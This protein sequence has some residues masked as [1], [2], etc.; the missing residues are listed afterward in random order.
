MTSASLSG[1]RK[2]CKP[3]QVRGQKS[4]R[5]HKRMRLASKRSSS[6]RR[7]S[8]KRRGSHA[9][10]AHVTACTTRHSKSACGSHPECDWLKR[11]GCVRKAGVLSGVRYEGP[12]GPQ[13]GAK[14]AK[15]SSK[16]RHRSSKKAKKSSKKRRRSSKKAKKSSKR[17]H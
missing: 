11:R 2:A 17:R 13:G 14:K 8:S 1:G 12:V 9:S 10:A 16:K 7:R 5:C 15:K 3:G 4:H 6:K